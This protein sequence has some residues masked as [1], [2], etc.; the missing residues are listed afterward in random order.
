M[1]I[2]TASLAKVALSTGFATAV[3]NQ[4]AAWLREIVSARRAGRRSSALYAGRVV[5]ALERFAF[6]CANR[7]EVNR[8]VRTGFL[9]ER[10]YFT[11][12]PDLDVASIPDSDALCWIDREMVSALIGLP[13]EIARGNLLI[14]RC[15]ETLDPDDPWDG[16][17]ECARQCGVLG[18]RAWELA[19]QLREGYRLGSANLS[20]LDNESLTAMTAAASNGEACK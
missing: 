11:T 18:T 2:D 1:D 3:F 15:V 4:G 8:S 14:G 6:A 7:V 17:A 13:D 19:G 10:G 9:Q 12:L 5:A 16:Y 20:G